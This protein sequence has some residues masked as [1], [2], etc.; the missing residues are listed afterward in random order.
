MWFTTCA[1]VRVCVLVVRQKLPCRMLC[2]KAKHTSPSC[3]GYMPDVEVGCRAPGRSACP[4]SSRIRSGRTPRRSMATA[5]APR[6]T[7]SSAWGCPRCWRMCAA[8]AP[9]PCQGNIP[10]CA[11]AVSGVMA[12]QAAPWL[13]MQSSTQAC[14]RYCRMCA[15]PAPYPS[16]GDTSG[17]AGAA[18]SAAHAFSAV[19]PLR[20]Q[21][22]AFT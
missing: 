13:C 9:Y 3:D 21:P 20:A 14:P 8:P 2:C 16:Q 1:G 15:A 7:P 17:F 5:C 10:G 22:V 11:G 19:A 6:W 4:A 18:C 12:L